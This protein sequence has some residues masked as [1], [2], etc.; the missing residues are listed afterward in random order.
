MNRLNDASAIEA[1]LLELAHTTDAKLT[2]PALAYFAPCSIDD[3][4]R[5]LDDLAAR[6][7]LSMEIEDDGTIVYQMPGRQ[8]L[9]GIPAPSQHR[10]PQ[11]ALVRMAAPA[12]RDASPL[13]AAA[14]TL[15]VPGTGHL[16]AGR[17]FAAFMWFLVVGL[18]YTLIL[19]GLVLHLF[20]IASAAASAHRVSTPRMPLMLAPGSRW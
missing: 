9:T 2:A 20:A 12:T 6:D 14:L 17:V 8:K 13:V 7:R 10:A 11:T 15:F 5:V 3:A 4:N 16:Y 18:G 1:R 19:P